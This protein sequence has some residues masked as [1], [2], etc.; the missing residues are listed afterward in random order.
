M[1][2][3]EKSKKDR[4]LEAQIGKFLWAE[5]LGICRIGGIYLADNFSFRFFN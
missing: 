3:Q 5:R 2:N 1:Y 4:V